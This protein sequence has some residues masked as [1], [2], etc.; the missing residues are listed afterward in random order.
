[1]VAS[2]ADALTSVCVLAE[3]D[4]PEDVTAAEDL[5]FSAD[6]FFMCVFF[7]FWCL[8]VGFRVSLVCAVCDE[9]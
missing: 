2:F 9:F 6:E 8:A 3:P 1:M 5:A 7:P 4:L